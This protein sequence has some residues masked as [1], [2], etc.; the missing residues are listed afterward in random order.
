MFEER[1]EVECYS[2]H[3]ADER[4]VAFTL[5]GRRFEVEQVVDRWYEG[6]LEPGRP[7]LRYFKIRTTEGRLFLLRYNAL[8]DAWSTTL[9]D[10][11]G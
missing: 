9:P 3:R 8:F 11:G 10:E 7:E 6:G 5:G 1:I 4:P 2:G